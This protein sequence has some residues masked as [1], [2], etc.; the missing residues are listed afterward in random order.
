MARETVPS[1]GAVRP[2]LVA[3]DAALE[4][5]NII[6]HWRREFGPPGPTSQ[7]EPCLWKWERIHQHLLTAADLIGVQEAGRRTLHLCPPGMHA[8]THTLSMCVQLNKPGEIATAHRH[9]MTALRFIIQGTGAYTTVE[10]EAVALYP[11][12][13]V[14]TPSWGYHDHWVEPNGS[15]PVIWVDG[16]DSPFVYLLDAKFSNQFPQPQQPRTVRAD[17]TRDLQ[18][19]VR[20]VGHEGDPVHQPAVYRWTEVRPALE[21]FAQDDGDPCDGVVLD[22]VN[23]VT[24]GHMGPTI[25]CR[26]QMLRVG[27]RTM[28]HRHTASAAYHVV[29]GEGVTLVGDRQLEW[30]KGDCFNIPNWQWHRHEQRG[31]SPAVLWSMHDQPVYEAVGL[32]R[33]ER[34]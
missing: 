29:E 4:A 30:S 27:E 25:G 20:P 28:G 26:I 10:G 5:D 2:E 34:R 31:G 9:T 7:G 6:A 18:G 22:Y 13:L 19:V 24:G 16:L 12:D 23:P 15:E 14:T 1:A 21:R 8:T 32:Y 33:E 3:F 17:F 11:G